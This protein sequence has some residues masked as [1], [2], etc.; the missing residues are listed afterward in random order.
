[1]KRIRIVLVSPLALLLVTGMSADAQS[2]RAPTANTPA[3]AQAAAAPRWS[4]SRID[5][6]TIDYGADRGAYASG[7]VQR[8]TTFISYYDATSHDL[9]VARTPFAL[10]GNC[11][12][13]SSW[14]C[15]TVDSTG[16]VGQ[17]SSLGP[18]QAALLY[19][20]GIAY[21]AS[22][23]STAGAL[24]F[25]ENTCQF[26][27][28][29]WSI[30]TIDSS[31][32]AAVGKYASFKYDSMGARHIAYRV[33][34]T[35]SSVLMYAH[36][37]S[38]GGN[39]GQGSAFGK[40]KCE[41]I[42]SIPDT[43]AGFTSLDLSSSNQPRIVYYD[44]SNDDLKYAFYTG[45]GTGNCGPGNNWWCGKVDSAGD[46]GRFVSMQIDHTWDKAHIAYYDATNGKLKYAYYAGGSGNCG[47]AFFGS[48]VW[49]CYTIDT[50]GTGLTL[51]GV[52]LAVNEK[53]YPFIAYQDASEE[54]APAM[55]KLARPW[56]AAPGES[57]NCGPADNPAPHTWVCNILD[58]GESSINEGDYVSIGFDAAGLATI[59][60]YESDTFFYNTG[61]L[62]VLRQLAQ[63]WLPLL[64]R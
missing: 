23:G 9:R 51:A 10:G 41:V 13:S 58:M 56:Y 11:G 15:E 4:G 26:V 48:I 29:I 39:C 40:W 21:Y 60:Y 59:A 6:P 47:D 49:R 44:S 52:S 28:C 33:V 24:K 17:Y 35:T 25:A 55:L 45:S 64:K 32:S 34:G 31:A 38:S 42:D 36:S 1:M 54:Q 61:Y 57:F 50:M 53:G 2:T 22:T 20:P 12:P 19:G 3:H 63:L 46:V 5:R 8:G 18:L 30:T 62:K 16:D 7:A 27:P 43:E 14:Y 37:V